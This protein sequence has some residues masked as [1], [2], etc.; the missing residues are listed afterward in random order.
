M[1]RM[2]GGEGTSSRTGK[3]AR[4]SFNS[5]HVGAVLSGLFLWDESDEDKF[6]IQSIFN[7]LFKLRAVQMLK[8]VGMSLRIHF[9]Y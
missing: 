5:I 4:S 3:Q 2:T 1:S 8:G 7:I 6:A 9:R